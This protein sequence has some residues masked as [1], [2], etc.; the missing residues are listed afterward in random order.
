V[1]WRARVT[2]VAQ[3]PV[4]ELDGQP[5]DGIEATV[6]K[7]SELSGVSLDGVGACLVE[8]LAG[9]HVCPDLGAAYGINAH[10]AGGGVAGA[11]PCGA[12]HRNS[13]DHGVFA[14]AE[15]SQHERRVM[16]AVRLAQ[17]FAVQHHHRVAPD[18]PLA[19]SALV[20]LVGLAF[21]RG[22]GLSSTWQRSHRGLV[23]GGRLHLE[24]DPARLQ[25]LAA[26]G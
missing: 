2:K 21:C 13:A 20:D 11:A 24:I 5:D 22:H 1:A 14:T 10:S 8:G 18:H 4:D 12:N 6:D 17:A 3:K 9:G 26:A 16:G 23:E 19:W 15:A 25:Q 7:M